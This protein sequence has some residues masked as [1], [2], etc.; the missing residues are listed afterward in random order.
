MMLKRYLIL[1]TRL[2][3]EQYQYSSIKKE[4]DIIREFNFLVEQFFSTKH[5]VAEY[6]EL[7]FKSPKTISNTFSKIGSKTPLSYIQDR[8]MLEARRLLYYTDIQIQEIGYKIGHNDIQ[9]FSRFFKNQ[10][11]ISPSKY[12][13]KSLLG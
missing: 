6:A 4:N 10:E 1:C 7:L 3:K 2:Y 5:T 12:R 11:G 13:E 8:K 9:A